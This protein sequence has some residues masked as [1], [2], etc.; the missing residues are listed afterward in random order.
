MFFYCISEHECVVCAPSSFPETILG[1]IQFY[2]RSDSNVKDFADNFEN[3]SNQKADEITTSYFKYEA[4]LVKLKS[5]YYKKFKKI[6]PAGKAA[7]FFQA[8]S[9][10][11][12]MVNARLAIDIPMMDTN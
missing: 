11:E 1:I 3:L 5:T 12:A 2:K 10:I 4:S 6:L 8:E 9:K 7:K